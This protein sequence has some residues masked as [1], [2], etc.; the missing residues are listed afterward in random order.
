MH[1]RI[2]LTAMTLMILAIGGETQTA[3]TDTVLEIIPAD[4]ILNALDEAPFR[5]GPPPATPD[6]VPHQQ[7]NQN[8]P[9]PMQEALRA[10]AAA[11]PGIKFEP[12]PFSLAGSV[13]W[14]LDDSF[15]QGPAEAFIRQSLEFVHQHV[16]ADGSMHML[17]PLELAGAALEKGWGVI[18]PLT[19]SISGE[20]SEYVMIFGPRDEDELNTIWI[21]AQIS[22]Y[23]ARGLS[24]E[25]KSSTSAILSATWGWVKDLLP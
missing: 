14:R 4:E 21:I 22:Y 9:V 5:E 20:N 10:S 1:A 11:L 25:P 16:P 17:L 24:M 7:L 6:G 2:L 15:A 3:T 23:Q 18:H 19:D 12:T 13:G 8:A